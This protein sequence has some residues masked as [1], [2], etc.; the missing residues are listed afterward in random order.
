MTYAEITGWGKC[1]PPA[2]LSNNDLS[3]FLDTS[4]EWIRSRT[5]IHQRHISHCPLH[6]LAAVAAD[7]ALACAGCRAGDIDVVILATC[8]PSSLL[9]NTAT[10]VQE[11]IGAENAAAFDLNAACSGFMYGLN[12]ATSMINSNAINRALVIGAEHLTWYV[13]WDLRDSA[14]LFGDGAGAVVVEGTDEKLGVLGYRLGNDPEGKDCIRVHNF[15]T[16][17]NVDQQQTV[18][19]EGREVFRKAVPGMVSMA[20]QAMEKAGVSLGDIDLVIPHQANLRIMEAVV[21]RLGGDMDKTFVNIANYGNTSAATI[22]I[23][24]CDAIEQGRLQAGYTLLCPAFGAG[25]TSAASVIRWGQR[26]RPMGNSNMELPP[27]NQSALQLIG[28]A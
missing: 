10:F 25:L 23:A 12:V 28:K 3:T 4:D 2:I 14:V 22:P 18:Q 26:T 15:G 16:S 7:R 21:N 27:C 13:N 17:M 5:G 19:F 11:A 20:Q 1:L 6:E 8:S 24:I 9:P